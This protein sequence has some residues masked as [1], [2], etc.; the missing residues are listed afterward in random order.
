M[1]KKIICWLKGH[2]WTCHAMKGIK[3]T[4]EQL[5]SLEGFLDYARMYCSRCGAMSKL[6]KK[7]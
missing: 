3:P 4:P 2:Q 5:Q 1:I 6:N 7:L